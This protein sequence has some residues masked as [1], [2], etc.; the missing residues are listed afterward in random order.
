MDAEYNH[1]SEFLELMHGGKNSP[2]E[3]PSKTSTV[4]SHRRSNVE[5]QGVMA[6]KRVLKFGGKKIRMD[7]PHPPEKEKKMTKK[8]TAR[9]SGTRE[10]EVVENCD[11]STN[12]QKKSRKREKLAIKPHSPIRPNQPEL[13]EI[14]MASAETVP[15]MDNVPDNQVSEAHIAISQHS[16]P[17]NSFFNK[18]FFE[19]LY[20]KIF[21]SRSFSNEV[22]E[23][24]FPLKKDDDTA[25]SDIQDFLITNFNHQSNGKLIYA[26]KVPPLP[27]PFLYEIFAEMLK[28]FVSNDMEDKSKE[29]RGI[30]E[31]LNRFIQKYNYSDIYETLLFFYYAY[32][33]YSFITLTNAK[34]LSEDQMMTIPSTIPVKAITLNK[35]NIKKFNFID[36]EWRFKLL[37]ALVLRVYDKVLGP[38]E[39]EDILQ[40]IR[41]LIATDIKQNSSLS[42]PSVNSYPHLIGL[43]SLIS[44][45]TDVFIL[46][47]KRLSFKKMKITNS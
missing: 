31:F 11:H 13:I 25:L 47:G 15:R 16:P 27:N 41:V 5:I 33:S 8:R 18:K 19:Q 1:L 44:F 28:F 20:F 35:R 22:G 36:K 32:E 39:N 38:G 12:K 10:K 2:S 42:E 21:A 7:T 40:V 43:V 6:D 30:K 26:E 4:S 45:L 14:E 9:E 23:K 34:V 29:L 24:Y 17:P 37:N 46:A 3:M